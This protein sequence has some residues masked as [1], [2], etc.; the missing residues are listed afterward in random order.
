MGLGRIV[1]TH[2][3]VKIGTDDVKT[4]QNATITFNIPRENVNAFGVSGTVDRPQLDAA[5]A[6]FEFS[7]IPEDST[8]TPGITGSNFDGYVNATLKNDPSGDLKD[9]VA[10][11]VGSVDS[12][13]M[14][15]LSCEATVGAMA[16]ATM[17]WTGTPDTTV[18]PALTTS[19]DATTMALVTSKDV[20]VDAGLGIACAQSLSTAWDV[21]VETVVCLGK[22][23]A[24]AANVHP[25]GNPPGTASITIEGLDDGLN[26]GA[27]AA[28]YT[29]TIGIY[30]FKLD[31]GRVDSQTNSLAVGDVF[32]TFNYVI[33]GTGDGYTIS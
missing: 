21:P 27:S 9:L 28:D 2:A 29:I 19:P 18:A 5:D 8:A 25:F 11:G 4:A 24:T 3:S 33:A 31:G 12:A 17:S 13:L 1:Y 16:N 26:V 22:D 7:F 23:P 32:G 15:S 14:N 20:T 10:E 30:S 6:T